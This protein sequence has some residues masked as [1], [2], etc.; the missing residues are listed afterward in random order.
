MCPKKKKTGMLTVFYMSK[1]IFRILTNCK[2]IFYFKIFEVKNLI[3]H[4]E[5]NLRAI[6]YL[7][8]RQEYW[9]GVP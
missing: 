3:T 6:N 4:M 7:I 9:S 5:N 8:S 2:L 1:S